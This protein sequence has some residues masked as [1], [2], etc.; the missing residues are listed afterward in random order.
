VS[1]GIKREENARVEKIAPKSLK[2]Q[3]FAFKQ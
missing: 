1:A 2:L 3:P